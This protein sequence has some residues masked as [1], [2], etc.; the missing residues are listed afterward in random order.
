MPYTLALSANLRNSGWVVKVFDLEGPETPHVTIRFKS[1]QSWRVSLR[2]KSFLD[3]GTWADI[4]EE[5]QQGIDQNLEQMRAY[6]DG[7]NPHN[8]IQ[9]EDNDNAN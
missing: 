4:P 8:P 9:S 6:W 2:D 5:I 3:G 7:Q 1:K